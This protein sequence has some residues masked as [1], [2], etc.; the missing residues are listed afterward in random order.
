MKHGSGVAFEEVIRGKKQTACRIVGDDH[1]RFYMY[2]EI[3]VPP[4]LLLDLAPRQEIV[5][6]SL[7]HSQKLAHFLMHAPHSPIKDDT[8][9]LAGISTQQ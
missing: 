5:F 6:L 1:R 2:D 9:A 7:V 8:Y 4:H 3:P